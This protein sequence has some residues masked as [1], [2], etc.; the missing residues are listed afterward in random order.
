MRGWTVRHWAIAVAVMLAAALVMGI[1]TGIVETPYYTRMTPVLW[2]N[3]PVWG[4]SSVLAGLLAGTYGGPAS[5][6]STGV[7]GRAGLGGVMSVLAVG[8]P[9]CNKVVVALLGVSGALGIWAPLQPLLGVA[10]VA[11]LGA[12]LWFRLRTPRVCPVPEP[13]APARSRH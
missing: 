2:W 10:S 3:Y 4:I 6:V 9:V 13:A 7:S 1:P 11:L 8:C 12:A 5:A